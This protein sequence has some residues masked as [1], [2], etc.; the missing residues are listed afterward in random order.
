[1]TIHVG[2]EAETQ[3]P[4]RLVSGAGEVLTHE[5]SLV[6]GSAGVAS[7]NVGERSGHSVGGK[8]SVVPLGPG[9]GIVTSATLQRH[10]ISYLQVVSQ[11]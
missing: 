9:V 5:Q 6:P 8:A 1:M 3:G 2:P 11:D 10:H 4:A 7:V